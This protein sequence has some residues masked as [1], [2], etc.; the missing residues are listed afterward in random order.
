MN[1]I[2]R[3]MLDFSSDSTERSTFK[4]QVVEDLQNFHRFQSHYSSKPWDIE[5]GYQTRQVRCTR[6]D[7]KNAM[8]SFSYTYSYLLLSLCVQEN[9][10]LT[11]QSCVVPKDCETSDWS[12]WSSC[13]KTC[14]SG[15]LSLGFRSR[16]RSIK[17][18]AVGTGLECPETEEREACS[19]GGGKHLYSCPRF[20][21]KTSE[22]K[23]CDVSLL[24]EQQDPRH[25]KHTG[26]CGGG[27]QVREV[28]CAQSTLE[29]MHKIKEVETES[30][31]DDKMQ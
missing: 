28:Y 29:E 18:T 31:C 10:P 30:A 11:F 23:E 5:I 2:G 4:L 20:E 17:H 12:S 26:L 6:S 13:S 7:G 21:W 27:I 22:W 9:I 19:I 15:D 14:H 25:S 24:L 16:T 8:L 1:M 3:T